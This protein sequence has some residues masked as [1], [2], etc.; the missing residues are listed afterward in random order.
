M[1]KNILIL[2]SFFAV[3]SLKAQVA[4]VY[5][6]GNQVTTDRNKATSYAIYGKLS[7]ENIWTFKRYDLYDNLIQT[8]SYEDETLSTP[9]GNFNFYMDIQ[10]FNDF[11]NT[12]FKLKGKTRFL[13]QQGNFVHGV[14]QGKWMV[15]YPDGNVLST[16]N[17]VNGELSGESKTFDKFGNVE[18]GGNYI[19]GK[20]DGEWISMEGTRKD[21]YDNGVLKS[22]IL[23]KQNRKEKRTTNQ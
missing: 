23:I 3:L 6:Y 13:S 2:F 22:S 21:L 4:P 9:H 15:Y 12:K 10:T 7:A 1:K 11:H 19:N 20:K 16:Q 14:E 17:Y 18:E 5:F 8:G